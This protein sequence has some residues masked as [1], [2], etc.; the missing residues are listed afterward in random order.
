VGSVSRRSA[1]AAVRAT[2]CSSRSDL[3][4]VVAGFLA[5]LVLAPGALALSCPN[6]PLDERLDGAD[7]AFVGRVTAERTV[8]GGH[9]YRFLVDQNVKGPI[10]REVE[11]RSAQRLVDANDKPILHDEALGVLANLDGARVV[12]EPCL[13]TDPGTLLSVS[14]EQKGNAIRLLIGILI[15][16]AVL[17]Y[18]IRRL[19]HRRRDLAAR[20]SLP[21]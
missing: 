14:D 16:A 1:R 5:A 15:L 2:P 4:V 18:S 10:G 11:V 17:A 7:A 21:R 12:T 3:R 9:V 13:L 19:R 6:V 8:A 20:S